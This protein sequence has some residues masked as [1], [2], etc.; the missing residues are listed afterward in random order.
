M[1]AVAKLQ[2]LRLLPTKIGRPLHNFSLLLAAASSIFLALARDDL[3][4]HHHA[5]AVHEGH[6]RETLAVL[7]SVAH[8][9]LLRLEAALCHLI[10]LQAMRILEF[11]ATGLLAH[12]PLQRGDPASGTAAAH[13]SN[14]RISNLDL[15]RNV[16]DL[17][18]SI[19]FAGLPERRVFL[20]DH[21]VAGP[22]HIVLVQ[23]LDAQADIVTGIGEIDTLVM[24]FDGENFASARV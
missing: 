21:D 12:L 17:D 22:R 8:E 18:L 19:K 23:A 7:E 3:A 11:L 15:I 1:S 13:K 2:R 24:H 10:G 6:P 5:V 16:Q 20:V 14:R 9:G 4:Q